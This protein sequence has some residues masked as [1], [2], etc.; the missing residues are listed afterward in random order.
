MAKLKWSN[1]TI[2]KKKNHLISIWCG[3][4]NLKT[5]KNQ[6]CLS[7]KFLSMRWKS[8]FCIFNRISVCCNMLFP[9]EFCGLRYLGKLLSPVI[10]AIQYES[11]SRI[12]KS[13]RIWIL[14]YRFRFLKVRAKLMWKT[15]QNGLSEAKIKSKIK[16]NTE[17]L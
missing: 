13:Y 6:K 8:A 16:L 14:S 10:S 4:Q 2:K 1:A 11:N 7:F 17:K 9:V 12:P 3:T 5:N 15:V